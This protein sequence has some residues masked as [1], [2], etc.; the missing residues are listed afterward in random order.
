[1][2]TKNKRA[3]VS[4]KSIFCQFFAPPPV[5][6]VDAA[7]FL[8]VFRNFEISIFRRRRIDN[9]DNPGLNITPM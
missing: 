4:E 6:L 5:V 3:E 9:N 1:M 2:N 7:D 8:P